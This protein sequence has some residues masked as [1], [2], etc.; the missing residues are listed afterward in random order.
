M[1]KQHHWSYSTLDFGIKKRCLRLLCYQLMGSHVYGGRCLLL[2]CHFT[3]LTAS[4][5]WHFMYTKLHK[6]R[7]ITNSL[8][9]KTIHKLFQF[10]V[11]IL[12]QQLYEESTA[13]LIYKMRAFIITY[14]NPFTDNKCG[15]DP[16]LDFTIFSLGPNSGA[17]AIA[18]TSE[19]KEAAFFQIPLTVV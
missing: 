8:S 16:D 12:R 13:W 18:L 9:F 19:S 3:C 1:E 5:S 7:C 15:V 4:S 6:I 17:G 14:L 2:L 11:Y 10:T